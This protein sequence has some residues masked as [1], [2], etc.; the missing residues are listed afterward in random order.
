MGFLFEGNPA[1]QEKLGPK[2]DVPGL[3]EDM[4]SELSKYLSVPGQCIL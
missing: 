2:E 1:K 4:V 3:S